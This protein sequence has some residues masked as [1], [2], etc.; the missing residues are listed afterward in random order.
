MTQCHCGSTK[1]F[2]T[3]CQPL[4]LNTQKAENPEQLMRS[5]YCAFVTKNYD[6]ILKTYIGSDK[7]NSHAD[8]MA[9]DYEGIHW[10]HLSVKNSGLSDDPN[11]GFV[12]FS[13]YFGMKGKLFVLEEES[14][15]QKV[16]NEW[17]Y[18]AEKSDSHNERV[19][20]SRNDPCICQS[21]KKFKKCCET[22]IS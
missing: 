9:E 14:Q 12:H 6:Y 2:Q 19:K 10:L 3:C 5:R 7:A 4:L 8:E 15:F 16:N 22:K 13:A 20:L 11:T 18:L 1:S 21:G 17:F